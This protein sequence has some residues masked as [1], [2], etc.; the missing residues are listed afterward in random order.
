MR[1][2]HDLSKQEL[3][4]TIE[5]L[6]YE[7]DRSSDCYA[8]MENQLAEKINFLDKMNAIKDVDHFKWRLRLD[9]LLTPQLEAFIDHYLKFNNFGRG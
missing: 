7:L 4:D 3:I 8:E 5:D 2:L 6:Q 1:N 9:N